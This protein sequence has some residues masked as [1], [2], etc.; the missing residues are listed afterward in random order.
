M[1]NA[2]LLNIRIPTGMHIIRFDGGLGNQMFGYAF[3]L[4]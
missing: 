4:F 3:Y 2:S 1:L